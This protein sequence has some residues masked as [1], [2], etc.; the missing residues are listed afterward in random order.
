L[1]EVDYKYKYGQFL[2][3]KISLYSPEC[4]IHYADKNT[5]NKKTFLHAIKEH[6]EYSQIVKKV[7]ETQ[8][9]TKGKKEIV[10]QKSKRIIEDAAIATLYITLILVEIAAFVLVVIWIF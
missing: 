9:N 2:L 4:L 6:N 1:T 5:E 10:K 3:Y 8:L 7:K